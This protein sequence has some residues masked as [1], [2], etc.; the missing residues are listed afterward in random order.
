MR[1]TTD[2][3]QYAPQG[4]PRKDWCS[5]QRHQERSRCY[6]LQE[7]QAPLHREARQPPSRARF[8]I[9][10]TRGVRSQSQ[11][12]RRA[13]EEVKDRWYPR[14]LEETTIDATGSEN[15]LD[16]GERT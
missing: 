13:Q 1:A 15:H 8:P 10:V 14:T 7:G 16:E 5:V 11:D 3:K 9:P 6:H 2:N 12:Q 4:L